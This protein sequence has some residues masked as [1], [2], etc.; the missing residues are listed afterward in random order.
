MKALPSAFS[1]RLT[2]ALILTCHSALAFDFKGIELGAETAT[3]ELQSGHGFTCRAEAEGHI[4]SGQTTIAGAEGFA[5]VEIN[6]SNRV[7][8]IAVVFPSDSFADAH[9]ACLAKFGKPTTTDREEVQTL[10]GAKLENITLH[11]AEANGNTAS[12]QRYSD[13]VTREQERRTRDL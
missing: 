2:T 11:W 8:S 10:G 13:K 9:E 12:L 6:G 5:L 3:A 4:C 7:I 1:K